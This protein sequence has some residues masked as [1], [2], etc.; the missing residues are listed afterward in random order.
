MK[1]AEVASRIRRLRV[2]NKETSLVVH[3][4]SASTIRSDTI[5]LSGDVDSDNDFERPLKKLRKAS[6]G[7]KTEESSEEVSSSTEE[8][9][10][11]VENMS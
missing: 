4:D 1:N 10:D 8:E 11:D 2:R 7:K 5:S 6:K 3:V 9:D